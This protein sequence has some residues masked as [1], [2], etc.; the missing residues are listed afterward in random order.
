[1]VLDPSWP[2]C[3][4]CSRARPVANTVP[5]KPPPS[6]PGRVT[7]PGGVKPAYQVASGPSGRKTVIIGKK[8]YPVYGMLVMKQSSGPPREFALFEERTQIGRDGTQ[9]RIPVDDEAV[10]SQHAA[11]VLR[12]KD[13][14]LHDLASTNGTYI[15]PKGYE[16]TPIGQPYKLNDGDVI[17]LGNVR[18]VFKR[19]W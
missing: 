3:P 16:D 10:S 12:D 5:N 15:N 2:T 6:D 14:V 11:I 7:M 8:E 19:I 18:L 13:F 4:V 1:M 9:C 17:G